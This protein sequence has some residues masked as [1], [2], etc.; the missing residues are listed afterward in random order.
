[1]SELQVQVRQRYK[2]STRID[3]ELPDSKIFVDDFILHGTAINILETISR[4]FEG[5]DQ[6]AYSITGPYGSGKSTVALFLSMLLSTNKEEREYAE[7]SLDC[8]AGLKSEFPNRFQLKKGWKTV[9]HVCAM[10]PPVHALLYSISTVLNVK[11]SRDEVSSF[12]EQ[13]CLDKI[14]DLLNSKWVKQDGVLILLDEMGKALDYC[15]NE[16]KDLYIFQQLADIVQSSKNSVLLI[17]FLHQPFSEYAKQK[18]S[19]LQQD[20]AKVQGRYRDLGYNPS[21][22]ESLH[23][24][25]DAISK[26]SQQVKKKIETNHKALVSVVNRAFKSKTRNV[27]DLLKPLPLDP[28]VSLLLGPISRRR[29]SQNERSLF[30][31]LASHEKYG[32]REYL[33]DN[34]HEKSKFNSL[35]S[36]NNLWDYLYHNLYHTIVTSPDSKAWLESCDAIDRAGKRGGELHSSLAKVIALLTLFG[37]TQHFHAT[38]EFITKYFICMGYKEDD[39]KEAIAD[40]EKWTVIIYRAAHDGYFIFEGSDID[41]N[42]LIKTQKGKL[43][44]GVDWTKACDVSGSVLATSHYHKTGTMRWGNKLIV[45][46]I[47][48]DLLNDLGIEDAHGKVFVNFV[49]PTNDVV[50]IKLK[51]LAQTNGNLVVGE[52]ISVI[53]LKDI[54]IEL[55]AL[56]LAKKDEAAVVRDKIA[57]KELESRISECRQAL[58]RELE[59]VFSSSIWMYQGKELNK[60]PLSSVASLVANKVFSAAPDIINELVNKAKPSGSAN[61]AIKKLLKA[62]SEYG[63]EAALDLPTATFPAEKGLYFSCLA[64]FG[65]HVKKSDGDYEFVMPQSDTPKLKALFEFTFDYIKEQNGITKISDLVNLWKRK[66]YGLAK[67]VIP[68]WL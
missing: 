25:G 49:I 46:T 64:N 28:L 29:F 23:L 26:T 31:F 19:K 37:F 35:Y 5:S 52:P 43:K 39:V 68:I 16:G 47:D 18:D 59:T 56:E 40:L 67:G 42:Q 30:G 63:D 45:Q 58:L 53:K 21:V 4:D 17:G 33:T 61:S 38:V 7:A 10:E 6:R 27:A 48:S 62:M 24:L 9:K 65:L 11:V 34:Y 14:K 54:A 13:Q 51:E 36:V 55:V 57:L 22:D 41:I 3:S 1:M 8:A 60:Q 32:F 20:W 66:P 50:W 44:S 12:T 15:A 2:S